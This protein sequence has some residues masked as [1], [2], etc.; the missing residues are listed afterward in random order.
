MHHY[1]MTTL[2]MTKRGA[3]TIPPEIRKRLGL[4]R[5][6]H[7][8]LIAEEKDGGLF[9]QPAVATPIRNIPLTTIKTWI[10]EDEYAMA[11]LRRAGKA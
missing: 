9:I 8:L 1:I 5:V 10:Q 4:D 3:I 2:T 6:E 11:E 7:P